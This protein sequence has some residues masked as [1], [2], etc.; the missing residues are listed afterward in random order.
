MSPAG[1]C[2]SLGFIMDRKAASGNGLA[3]FGGLDGTWRNG[4]M[5]EFICDQGYPLLFS[6]TDWGHTCSQM[7]RSRGELLG[8]D[9]ILKF[10]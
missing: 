9:L 7:R 5:L 10:V 6:V 1:F 8:L 3:E 4:G 2:W